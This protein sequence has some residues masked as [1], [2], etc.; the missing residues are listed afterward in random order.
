MGAKSRF[1][2][3]FLIKFIRPARELAP[4]ESKYADIPVCGRDHAH[5]L[6]VFDKF[7]GRPFGYK[8]VNISVIDYD[9]WPYENEKGE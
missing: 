8:V 7:L 1:V 5:A 4:F 2:M 9:P 3:T 6:A